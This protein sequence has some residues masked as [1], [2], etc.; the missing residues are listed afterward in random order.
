[1]WHNTNIFIPCTA[2]EAGSGLIRPDEAIFALATF[3]P[4]DSE[5]ADAA[6]STRRVCDVVGWCSFAGPITGNKTCVRDGADRDG[7]CH[8]DYARFEFQKQFGHAK[9]DSQQERSLIR[10]S[11][12]Q[13]PS[14][15]WFMIRLSLLLKTA[16]SPHNGEAKNFSGQGGRRAAVSEQL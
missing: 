9:D 6:T 15:R 8:C 12:A 7:D 4:P 5:N 11:A 2:N 1:L 14:P 16:S 10:T 3:E 13:I